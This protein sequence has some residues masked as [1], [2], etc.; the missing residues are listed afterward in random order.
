MDRSCAQCGAR[1]PPQ[2]GSARPRKFCVTCRP[3]RN[4]GNPRVIPM[5]ESSEKPKSTGS[6]VADSYRRRL[7]SAGVLD[8]PE[9]SHVMLLASL[10]EDGMGSHTAAGAASLSRELR[11]AM[12]S[13]LR[14]V[15][16]EPDVVDELE[17]RRRQ[18]AAGA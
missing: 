2:Q 5:S 9:G 4:R 14:D 1:I 13:A 18:K 15:P 8:T 3:S 6:G 7:D 17:E 16:G 12:E 10:L 11:A